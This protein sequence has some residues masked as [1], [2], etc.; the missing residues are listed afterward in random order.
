MEATLAK[1]QP[2]G[3]VTP[4][5]EN[6]NFDEGFRQ[7]WLSSGAP[8]DVLTD[9]DAMIEERKKRKQLE[10]TAAQAQVA[11]TASKAYKNVQ[12][13]PEEGSVAEQLV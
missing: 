12:A 4:V 13:A 11:E 7:S 1:W 5:Y 10:E 6:V 9:F 3:E 8:A 2:Y